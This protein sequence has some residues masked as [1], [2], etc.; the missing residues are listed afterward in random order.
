[1]KYRV[2]DQRKPKPL[3]DGWYEARLVEVGFVEARTEEE[4]LRKAHGLARY[5]VVQNAGAPSTVH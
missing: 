2:Y 5:P 4:A 1:M 3:A